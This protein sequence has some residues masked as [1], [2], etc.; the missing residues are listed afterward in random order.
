MSSLYVSSADKDSKIKNKIFN[1]S[2]KK[3]DEFMSTKWELSGQFLEKYHDNSTLIK[4]PNLELYKSNFS[5]NILSDTAFDPTGEMIEIYLKNNVYINRTDSSNASTLK[6]YT[7]Y[8]IFYLSKDLVET[9]RDVTIITAN[10]IT[11]GS[12]L[13]A[14]LESGIIS[15][16]SNAERQIKDGDNTRRIKGNQ[17]I[18]NTKTK[19]WIVKNKPALKLKNSIIKKVKTT[20]SL[21]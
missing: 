8:A 3:I 1:F 19:K 11:T 6:L 15:V 9:D 16:L 7:S 5:T 17:M 12:G 21:D 13:S 10:S 20:F 14:N 2:S 4:N 18:Y